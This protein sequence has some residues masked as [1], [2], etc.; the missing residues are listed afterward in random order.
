MLFSVALIHGAIALT[1]LS[2]AFY[3]DLFKESAAVLGFSFRHTGDLLFRRPLL[4]YE[5]DSSR[6]L[7]CCA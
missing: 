2:H 3:Y 6:N 1:A 5:T 4:L 7:N